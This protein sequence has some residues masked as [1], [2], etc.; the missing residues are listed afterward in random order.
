MS[1]RCVARSP[2]RVATCFLGVCSQGR[3][4]LLNPL[5]L[6]TLMPDGEEDLGAWWL[7]HCCHMDSASQPLFDSLLLLITWMV[8]KE[9][10]CRVFGRSATSVQALVQAAVKEGENWALAVFAPMSVLANLWSQSLIA[11]ER[12]KCIQ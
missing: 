8:W 9:R 4:A 12:F 7:R 11:M 3:F 1:A 5:Q 10:N 6:V 2:R